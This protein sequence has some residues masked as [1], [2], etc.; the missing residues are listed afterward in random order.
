M[1]EIT[2]DELL[3]LQDGNDEFASQEKN[4][5]LPEPR[6]VLITSSCLRQHVTET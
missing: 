5:F 2:I 4:L 1:A 6:F 3:A